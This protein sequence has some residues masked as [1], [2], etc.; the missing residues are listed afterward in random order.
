MYKYY[1]IDSLNILYIYSYIFLPVKLQT[2]TLSY[3]L[4]FIIILNIYFIVWNYIK[5]NKIVVFQNKLINI[6]NY[7]LLFLSAF[8]HFYITY[9]YIFAFNK[10]EE[11]YINYT[12]I[13]SFLIIVVQTISIFFLL[14]LLLI[15]H[16]VWQIYKRTCF[17][18]QNSRQKV[19]ILQIIQKLPNFSPIDNTMCAICLEEV[20]NSE[21]NKTWKK[22]NCQ[23]TFH[24]QCLND[25]FLINVNCPICRSI[26]II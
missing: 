14:I 1:I 9:F 7:F 4:L 18:Q 3:T 22:L 16:I 8:F 24:D 10:I 19:K 17:R 5:L 23:H 2:Q 21:N 11:L 15:L 6:I 12:I 25:W 13:Y 26:E 20:D